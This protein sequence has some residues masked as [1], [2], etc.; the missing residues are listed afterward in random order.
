MCAGHVRAEA[1]FSPK[2]AEEDE[3]LSFTLHSHGL[4]LLVVEDALRLP[5]RLFGAGDAVHRRCPLQAGCRV[6]DVS[7][8]DPFALFWASTESHYRLAGVDADADLQRERRVCL[9]Q[10]LDRL[11]DAQSGPD[12]ALDV[13]LVRRRRAEHR[14]D[15]VPDELFDGAAVALDVMPQASVVGA[16]AGPDV[17]GV[18]R[19]GSCGEPDEI[20]EEDGDDLALLVK[21]GRRFLRQGRG[22]KR[23]EG[24]LAGRVLAA[25]GACRHASESRRTTCRKHAPEPVPLSCA[26]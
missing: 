9:V 26:V 10:L 5:V 23:A 19:I 24:E 11:Q 22:T 18:S 13:V 12:G 8:D 3:G 2:R 17:L 14:H 7:R 20:A 4:E 6:D 25:G 1:G 16:D 15:R 21:G